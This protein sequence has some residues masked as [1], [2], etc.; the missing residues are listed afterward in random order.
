M[1]ASISWLLFVQGP[2]RF[3]NACLNV[4][5]FDCDYLT[6][7]L[8]ATS[9][10]AEPYAQQSR[11]A[12]D[13]QAKFRGSLRYL[14][15]PYGYSKEQFVKFAEEH[16]TFPLAFV[17][18]VDPYLESP[19]EREFEMVD[20]IV[21]RGKVLDGNDLWRV[22]GTAHVWRTFILFDNHETQSPEST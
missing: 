11:A 2:V 3:A 17:A 5:G 19:L 6:D 16:Y 20:P 21:V 12:W 10:P 1:V 22:Q 4:A 9:L 18:I 7:F 15:L 8:R 14:S 13:L